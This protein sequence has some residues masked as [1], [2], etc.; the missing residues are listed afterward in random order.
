MS[1]PAV[2]TDLECQALRA[3]LLAQ[4]PAE[5]RWAAKAAEPGNW[6]YPPFCELARWARNRMQRGRAHGD[7]GAL[8]ELLRR[9]PGLVRDLAAVFEFGGMPAALPYY[10]RE[11]ESCRLQREVVALAERWLA[12]VYR[13]DAGEW[14]EMVRKDVSQ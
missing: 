11:L 9:R 6:T 10:V 2:D 1:R 13:M 14:L 5:R 3:V 8:R 7:A 4:R 12:A